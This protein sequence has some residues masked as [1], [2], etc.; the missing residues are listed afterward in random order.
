[1]SRWRRI[2]F[3]VQKRWLR[4]R[5]KA[6]VRS[7][8]WS[9]GLT[10]MIPSDQILRERGQVITGWKHPAFVLNA[11]QYN[12]LNV[13]AHASKHNQTQYLDICGWFPG[14]LFRNVII[15]H[16]VDVSSNGDTVPYPLVWTII[17]HILICHKCS[18]KPNIT[19]RTN[20]SNLRN[21][22][23]TGIFS[24][25]LRSAAGQPG[26]PA[27]PWRWTRWT[28]WTA[29]KTMN[30]CPDK[31][32]S[33]SGCVFRHRQRPF[34]SIFRFWLFLGHP[35]GSRARYHVGPIPRS[36]SSILQKNVSGLKPRL[37]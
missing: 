37:H 33:D 1:M 36:F 11:S 24:P 27:C 35:L 17:L 30:E 10:I 5:S 9:E 23:V 32:G 7:A 29:M 34:L 6:M 3:C 28:R 15:C 31:G 12:P 18:Q 22:P 14:T 21:E 4:T 2:I 13:T 19:Q 8:F 25:Q 20:T 16:P 26:Q